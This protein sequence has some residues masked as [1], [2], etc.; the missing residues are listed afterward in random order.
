MYRRALACIFSLLCV[1]LLSAETVTVLNPLKRDAGEEVFRLPVTLPGSAATGKYQVKL[2]GKELPCQVESRFGKNHLWTIASIKAGE[3]GVFSVEK[4]KPKVMRTKVSLRS[5]NGL[6]VLGN[7]KVSVRVPAERVTDAIPP[8][9]DAVRIG[10]KWVGSGNWHSSLK[11]KDFSAKATGAGPVFA[12]V[13]L[14][15]LFDGRAGLYKQAPAFADV[16]V[17]V[18]AGQSH[19]V[20]EEAHEMQPG[21]CWSFDC[22]GGWKA[23]R[24]ICRPHSGG[25]ERPDLGPWP[26]ETLKT[27]QTRMG[28]TLLNLMPRWTQAYDEGWFFACHDGKDALGALVCRAG[29][30][31]W[32][33][34]NMIEVKVKE[35]GD[36]AG[37]LCP[38]WK[39]RRY[40]FLVAGPKE[41]WAESAAKAYVKQYGFYPLDRVVNDF[42]LS[43]PEK[44]AKKR[45]AE[46]DFYNSGMNPTGMMRGFG[47]NAMRQIDKPGTFQ[48]LTEVQNLLSPDAYGSYWNYWSPE[49]PNFYTDYIRGPIALTMRLKNHPDFR[50]LARRA[51]EVFRADLYH[52]ITLPGGAGQECPGYVAHAMKSW[53]ALADHCR[54]HLGFDPRSWPRFKAGASF[55]LHLSQPIAPGK[56]RCHPGGDTHPPGPDVFEVA[57]KFGVK[58]DVRSFKTEEL[59]GFGVVFRNRPGTD[60]ETYLAFKSGP[61]RG[62]YHGDQLS[63][64]LCARARQV[65]I[66]HMCSYGPRA[67]QE[68]MHN[69]VAFHTGR[70]PYANMDGYERVIAFK[71]SD[72]VDVAVGQVESDRLRFTTNYPPEGWDVY[73]PQEKLTE[74][75]SY[76]RTIVLIKDAK[77]DFFVIRD[78]Y[79]GPELAATYCLHV[80]SETCRQEGAYFK[81]NNLTLFCAHPTD[82]A[83]SHH[84]WTFEKKNR[85]KELI[86]REATKGIR[87]TQ[88]GASGSFVTV[89]YPGSDAPSMERIENGVRVGETEVVFEGGIDAEAETKYISVRKKGKVLLTLTGD[90]IDMNRF[91]GEVGLFIPDAGYPFGTVP[92]WL[93]KQRSNVPPWAPSWVKEERRFELSR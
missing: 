72:S 62:H 10:G 88:S 41:R 50:T 16:T 21:D 64:H 26:P 68:H 63:F 5:E 65:A 35:S 27:A 45:F 69:R 90:D 38:T 33:H 77:Q 74:R 11:L 14:A 8:P 2:E 80:L 57:E 85:N 43:R 91:Q 25:F 24:A 18:F 76:R 86:I 70:L 42:I 20:I 19:A 67:G 73:L 66:D 55:L 28:D 81:F 58:E 3:T 84:D 48:T 61:N 13:K 6:F 15:Y 78:Q 17:T 53:S 22:A 47:R 54:R 37:L 51:E 89:L 83:V 93:I 7:G 1:L 87:L 4:K 59:P 23:R 82:V 71:T 92:D 9:I 31:H 39:G 36:Y 79:C 46:K 34:N 60:R 49:N 29:R 75:L 12:Q 40:W 56:R 52:S 32:P 44:D 30:W